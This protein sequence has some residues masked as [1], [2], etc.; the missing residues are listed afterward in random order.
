MIAQLRA[1][2]EEERQA[3]L[4]QTEQLRLSLD[5]ECDYRDSEMAPPPS[6]PEMR[7]LKHAL[8]ESLA[9]HEHAATA[10]A[11]RATL[12]RSDRDRGFSRFA[13]LPPTHPRTHEPGAIV[14][15]SS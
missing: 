8:Q 10:P 6:V 5:D 1:A 2:L 12:P 13:P 7:Q 3:L 15:T 4:A 9:A 11:L 14:V